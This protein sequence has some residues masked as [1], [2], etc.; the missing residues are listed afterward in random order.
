MADMKSPFECREFAEQCRAMANGLSEERR[1]EVL[2]M[3]DI[4]EAL[5]RDAE[6]IGKR[7]WFIRDAGPKRRKVQPR[8]GQSR[9][10]LT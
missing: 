4:W 8:L 2:N 1:R 6:S 5:A 9:E 3:A 7:R 10:R